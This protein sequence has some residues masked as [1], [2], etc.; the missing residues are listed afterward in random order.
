MLEGVL[1]LKRIVGDQKN[2]QI[3][4]FGVRA[5]SQNIDPT[6]GDSREHFAQRGWPVADAH[7]K[8]DLFPRF[9]HHTPDQLNYYTLVPRICKRNP[10]DCKRLQRLPQR[11]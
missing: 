4:A 8:F 1:G 10:L 3:I 11:L 2:Y 7:C 6:V 5:V 9:C